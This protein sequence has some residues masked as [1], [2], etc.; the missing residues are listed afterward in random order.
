MAKQHYEHKIL[1]K[2]FASWQVFIAQQ[3]YQMI[4]AQGES[5]TKSKMST[6]LETIEAAQQINSD[7]SVLSCGVPENSI[8]T[9]RK[10]VSFSQSLKLLFMYSETSLY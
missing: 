4:Y 3:Q 9:D 1:R 2:Y 6:F 10:V 8:S 5:K 7:R